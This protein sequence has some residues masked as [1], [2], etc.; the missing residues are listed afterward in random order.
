MSYIMGEHHLRDS[1]GNFATLSAIRR[2][3]SFMS[4]LAADRRARQVTG[5]ATKAPTPK[6][7]SP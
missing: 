3:S 7:Q 6:P 2:A 5:G 4:N 1:D